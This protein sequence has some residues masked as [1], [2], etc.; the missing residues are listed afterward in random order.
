MKSWIIFSCSKRETNVT[1]FADPEMNSRSYS[2][3]QSL[4]DTACKYSNINFRCEIAVGMY[5]SNTENDRMFIHTLTLIYLI[6]MNFNLNNSKTISP[7]KT[8]SQFS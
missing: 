8:R 1:T 6:H 2:H 5:T 4:I 3:L 7:T